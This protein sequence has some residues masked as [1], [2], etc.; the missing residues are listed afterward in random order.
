[1]GFVAANPARCSFRQL[2]KCVMVQVKD[3]PT[4]TAAV[5]VLE[6]SFATT[7]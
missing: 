1:M 2:E 5:R 6:E 3:V 7:A 4:I